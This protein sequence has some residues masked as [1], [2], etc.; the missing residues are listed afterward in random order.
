VIDAEHACEL[1]VMNRVV[2]ASEDI[3]TVMHSP[4]VTIEIPSVVA[5]V[6]LL[7]PC[8]LR[9]PA[10]SAR[11]VR[12]RDAH[13]CQFV[14]DGSPCGRRGDSVDHLLPRSLGGGDSWL[15]AVAACRTHNGAK[16]NR[17]LEQMHRYHGV[18]AVPPPRLTARIGSG[19]R[20]RQLRADIR[21]DLWNR[22]VGVDTRDELLAFE[23]VDDRPRLGVVVAQS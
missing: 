2:A 20:Q 1:V 18:G 7:H 12:L 15:N 14:I 10:Y 13:T 21:L 8:E 16:A 5:R 9:P 11:R 6:G 22:P 4:S 17:T 3:A 19:G 23:Q